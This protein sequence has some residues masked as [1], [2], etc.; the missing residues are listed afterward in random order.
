MHLPKQRDEV[1]N[2]RVADAFSNL[3]DALIRVQKP[4]LRFGHAAAISSRMCRAI[5]PRALP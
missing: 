2:V 5:R 1:C 3:F 4:A